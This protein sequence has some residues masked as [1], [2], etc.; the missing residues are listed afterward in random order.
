MIDNRSVRPR[1][2]YLLSALEDVGGLCFDRGRGPGLHV[3]LHGFGGWSLLWAI[4]CKLLDAPFNPKMGAFEVLNNVIN[5]KK[6]D[7]LISF[8]S[9]SALFGNA[10]QT[11]YA[12]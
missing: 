5:M 7:F 1:H 3:T 12:A 2:C 10:G 11:N 9:V 8:S 6:L 4:R